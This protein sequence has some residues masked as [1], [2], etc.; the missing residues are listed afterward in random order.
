MTDAGQRRYRISRAVGI[1]IGVGKPALLAI[2]LLLSPL[3][4]A[5]T[6]SE[7]RVKA[8][9]VFNLTNSTF[10]VRWSAPGATAGCCTKFAKYFSKRARRFWISSRAASKKT[11]PTK[12]GALLT[13]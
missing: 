2:L 7:F 3:M 1:C 8:A 5:Q 11:K 6:Q 10:P 4:A 13:G 12:C 9:F